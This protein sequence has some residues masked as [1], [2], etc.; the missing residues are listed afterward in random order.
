MRGDVNVLRRLARSERRAAHSARLIAKKLAKTSRNRRRALFPRVQGVG[1]TRDALAGHFL[2]DSHPETTKAVRRILHARGTEGRS[3]YVS[4]I[5]DGIDDVVAL[6]VVPKST[7]ATPETVVQAL[8][9]VEAPEPKVW[10]LSQRRFSLFSTVSESVPAQVAGVSGHH[11]FVRKL[12]TMGF[13][14]MF[15]VQVEPFETGQNSTPR[16]LGVD[17]WLYQ[18]LLRS[19]ADAIGAQLITDDQ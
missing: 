2:C 14:S 19:A 1:W 11:V 4:Q 15:Y 3:F 8:H 12:S 6:V 7:T 10:H 9:K 16:A 5:M 17:G 18:R 13:P